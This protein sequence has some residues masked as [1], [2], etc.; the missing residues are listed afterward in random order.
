MAGTR[1]APDVTGTASYRLVSY[2]WIDASGTRRADAYQF[3]IATTAAQIEALADALQAASNASLW[4]VSLDSVFEGDMDTGSADS[5]V[6][7]GV[8]DNIVI[9]AKDTARN[10]ANAFIPAPLE[11]IFVPD[12]EDIIQDNAELVAV[13]TAFDTALGGTFTI[14]GNRFTHRSQRGKFTPK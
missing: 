11:A 8:D 1:T 7:A 2:R 10:S 6:Y 13:E 5:V 14:R 4:S 12:T 9:L 3:P